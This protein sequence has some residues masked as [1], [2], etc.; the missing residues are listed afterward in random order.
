MSGETRNIDATGLPPVMRLERRA[1][2][3]HV[4]YVGWFLRL[5]GWDIVLTAFVA[6]VPVVITLV[7]PG[8]ADA[9]ELIAVPLPIGAFIL[10]ACSGW[11]HIQAN[12]CDVQ[13]RQQQTNAFF[14]AM[15]M[16]VTFDT[17]MITSHI[18]PAPA[19]LAQI[20]Y[21]IYGSLFLL[22]LGL[23]AYAMYPGRVER[24][25]EWDAFA[26]GERL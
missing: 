25:E 8:D 3:G 14:L 16:L 20:D 19:P 11:H 15:V 1:R 21:F 2:A 9:I 7:L 5:L 4:D 6:I 18:M 10:R 26:R 23:M 13:M 12:G 22:Y 24:A 17:M